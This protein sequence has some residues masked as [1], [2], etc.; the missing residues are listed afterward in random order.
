MTEVYLL[1]YQSALQTFIHFNLFLQR[2]D[3][4]IPVIDDQMSTFLRKL[5]SKF[6]TVQEIRNANGNFRAMD[7]KDQDNQL[8]GIYN[9]S[10][11]RSLLS[12]N[13]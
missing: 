6:V 13:N 10:R 9:Q 2:E 5:A 3:P 8:S 1:F 7:F 11:L 12:K 4:V